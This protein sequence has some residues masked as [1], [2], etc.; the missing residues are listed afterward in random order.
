MKRFTS[1][2]R[3]AAKVLL[4]SKGFSDSEIAS[5]LSVQLKNI[6]K[7]SREQKELN[8]VCG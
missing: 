8:N 5:L 1:K 6:K 2:T 7:L 3:K 4:H